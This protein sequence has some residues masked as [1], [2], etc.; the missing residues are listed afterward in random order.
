MSEALFRSAHQALLYA[1]TF[2][3]TQ[4]GTAAAAERQIALAARERYERTA[5]SGRG[6]KGLDGA[7]QAGQIKS[8]VERNTPPAFQAVVLARYSL[9]SD[10]V[11]RRACFLLAHRCRNEVPPTVTLQELARLIGK[12]TGRE[13]NLALM[14]QAAGVDERTVRRWALAVRKFVATIERPGMAT[15]EPLL[16]SA[17]VVEAPYSPPEYPVQ[18]APAI[19]NVRNLV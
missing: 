4:H 3:A 12:A 18:S 17:G 7:A 8:L 2:S 9:L 5:G 14:A 15:I 19:A 6:L 13:V 16:Q 1:Y 10:D 11:R